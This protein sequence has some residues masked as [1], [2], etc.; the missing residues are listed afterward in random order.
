ML[1]LRQ[2]T[3]IYR[4]TLEAVPDREPLDATS[5]LNCDQVVYSNGNAVVETYRLPDKRPKTGTVTVQSCSMERPRPSDHV[6]LEQD[7]FRDQEHQFPYLKL[8]G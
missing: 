2:R 6:S 7:N 1:D 4:S 8:L 3:S 5:F